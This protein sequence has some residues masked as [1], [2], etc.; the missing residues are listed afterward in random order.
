MTTPRLDASAYRTA[1]Q[2]LRHNRRRLVRGGEVT[3]HWIEG[4]ARFW[5]AADTP[6]GVSFVLV[7][8]AAGTREPAFDHEKVA[9][10]LAETAGQPVDA[11]ALPFAAVHLITGTAGGTVEAV[12]FAAFG[13]HWRCAADGSACERVPGP[14]PAGPLEV[15]SPD[16]RLAVFRRGHDLWLRALEDGAERPLTTGGD[17][18]HDCGASPDFFM[19]S[20]LLQRLGLPHAPPAAAWS[21]DSSR[22]LTH[23]TL[24]EGV[25]L[26]HLVDALPADGG[27]PR[28]VTLRQPYPGDERLPAAE[29]VVLDVATGAVVTARAEPEAMPTFSPVLLGWAWWAEDGSAVHYLSRSRDARTLRLRRLDP[30]TGEVTTLVEEAGETRVEPSQRLDRPPLVRVLSGRE[31]L[32]YSQRDGWGHLYLYDSLYDAGAGEPRRQVTSGEWAVQEILHVDEERRVVTFTAS[33]LVPGDPYRRQVCRAGL[34][35]GGVERITRDDLDHAAVVPPCGGYVVDTASTTG[36]PPVTS[37]LGPDGQVIMELGRADVSGLVATGWSAPER[38]RVKAADGRTDVYG[39]LHRPHGFDPGRR[40]PV[41]DHVYPFPAVTRVSPSF[42]PGW[43]GYDAEAVAALGFVVVALDGRGT[44]GRDKEFHDAS[45]RRLGEAGLA[46]HVAALEQLGSTRP[47][48]DLGRVGIFGISAGGQAT[49]RAMLD[50]PDVFT[51]GVAEAGMHDLRYGDPGTAEAYNG[52]YDEE[53]Y[54]AT[55]N[56]DRADRLEG[57]LLLVHGGRDTQ[58]SPHLTLRLAERLIAAGKDFDML[59]VPG[60]EHVFAGYE[61]YVNRRKWDFL[62]RHLLGMEPP[63]DYHLT[64]VPPGM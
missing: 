37:L 59:I 31:V 38:F 60:A 50:H 36:T 26:T 35:G 11:R 19:Y 18:D 39:V 61:H 30:A 33:G 64:P 14:P 32:W 43:H 9:A 45:Y 62:V 17:A 25:R 48:M 8:P 49:V 15:R 34:D 2:L 29:L 24:Q 4:G 5:Y 6:G 56:V 44:P 27:E 47:W 12:E 7:D 20:P 10:A 23:R 28:L 52:P 21:P 55:S 63:E 58:V 3:P 46:D 57:R 40:Y 51:V 54:A 42:D 16:G 1:E 41:L 22:V 13:A 53:T